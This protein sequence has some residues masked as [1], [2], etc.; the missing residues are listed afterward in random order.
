LN[1]SRKV[2][3]LSLSGCVNRGLMAQGGK[4]LLAGAKRNGQVGK[5]AATF[6]GNRFFD[7]VDWW[8]LQCA[9]QKGRVAWPC[10]SSLETVGW[11]SIKETINLNRQHF[12]AIKP[13]ALFCDHENE[14]GVVTD[15]V[16]GPL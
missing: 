7:C 1:Q 9:N 3:F 2:S 12:L 8:G 15:P 13:K 11:A 4:F 16:L 14:V 6:R 5:L 10:K